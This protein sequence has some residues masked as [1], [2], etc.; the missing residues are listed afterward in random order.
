MGGSL[1]A[2]LA[3]AAAS[4]S[5]CASV[6]QRFFVIKAVVDAGFDVSYLLSSFTTAYLVAT[7]RPR[8]VNM[9]R[10]S[11]FTDFKTR[12]EALL[13]CVLNKDGNGKAH[14]GLHGADWK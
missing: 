1:P 11:G 5:R 3:M 10:A 2:A 13:T 12:A 6:E 4:T 7:L 14:Q 9:L 8:T